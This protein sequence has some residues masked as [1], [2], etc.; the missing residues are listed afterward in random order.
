A[1]TGRHF[2]WREARARLAVDQPAAVLLEE[3]GARDRDHVLRLFEADVGLDSLAWAHEAGVGALQGQRSL[4]VL[5]RRLGA[6]RLG[7]RLDARDLGRIAG[8]DAPL[9]EDLRLRSEERRVG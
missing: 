1:R 7:H 8:S 3:G 4:E 6:A 9:D 2:H 5:D